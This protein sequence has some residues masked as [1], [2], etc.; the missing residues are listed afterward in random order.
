M[1][2]RGINYNITDEEY[3]TNKEFMTRSK[4]LKLGKSIN[5]F[6]LE[7]PN[8]KKSKALEI[9]TLL[10]DYL[11]SSDKFW[12]KY[13][14][15]FIGDKRTKAGK[16]AFKEYKELNKGKIEVKD[17]DLELILAMAKSLNE[18]KDTQ[19]YFNGDYKY[20]VVIA[21]D[22]EL[23]G[24]VIPF[25]VKTDM[26]REFDD[27]IEVCDLKTTATLDKLE[28][29]IYDWG[30]YIQQYLY[31][32]LIKTVTGKSVK[33][34]FTF[35]EKAFPND[36][37]LV[38]LEPAWMFMANDY[39]TSKIIPRFKIANKTDKPIYPESKIIPIPAWYKE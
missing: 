28:R 35:V 17:N 31:S 36:S 30:Y 22:L 38:S 9:G 10:D 7:N 18:N 14:K 4:L 27:Y 33:W 15:A 16:E 20:Q 34:S 21:G 5:N 39:L 25:M 24:E 37:I 29:S 32:K 6:I 2:K 8:P 3:F 1:I 12:T 19:K 23:G 11:T 13:C 26:W